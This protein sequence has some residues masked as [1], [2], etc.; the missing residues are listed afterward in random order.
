MF[1]FDTYRVHDEAHNVLYYNMGANSVQ[2]S[3][4]TYSSYPSKEGGKNKTVGQFEVIGKA[5]DTSLGGFSFDVKL[6]ELM[7]DRFNAI[8][9]K[10]GGA[11]QDLRTFVRPMTRLRNEAVKIKEVLSA[12]NEYPIKAEQLHANIDLVGKITRT[13]LE[14]ACKDLFARV[15]GPIQAALDM[16]NITIDQ[17]H[18]VELLGGGV[19]IPKVKKLLDDFFKPAKLDLGQHLNGDE[20]MALGASFRAAN[21]S[22]AFRVRKVGMTDVNY[23]GVSLKLETLPSKPGFFSSLFGSGKK[24]EE[25]EAWTKQASLY[26][27]MSPVPAKTKVVAFT[28]DKDILCRVEYDDDVPLPAGTHPLV[29]VYNITGITDFAQETEGKGLG[30]PKVHLSFSLDSNGMV[31]LNKAEATVDLPVEAELEPSPATNETSSNGSDAPKPEEPTD[32]AAENTEAP[33]TAPGQENAA[34]EGSPDNAETPVDSDADKKEK[35]PEKDKSSKSKSGKK[36][37]KSSAPKKEKETVLRRVLAIL[38]NHQLPSPT[39]WTAAEIAHAGSRLR[40]LDLEDSLRRAKEAA[41]NELEAYVYQVKNRLM[42]DEKELSKVSTEEQR[43]GVVDAA[44]EAAEWIDMEG[45]KGEVSQFKA[46]QASLKDLAEPIFRRYSELSARPT[47]VSKAREQLAGVKI[48]IEKWTDTMPHIT[49]EE[50]GKL[51]S[52]VDKVVAWLDD[53]ETAQKGKTK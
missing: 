1:N 47:A 27:R 43:Q 11:G 51:R 17:L 40:A 52:E 4:V 45:A 13:E 3:I 28:Y 29:A 25:E 35:T 34:G 37:R 19:R 15:T 16:A 31:F 8:W 41:L 7:A 36:D 39:R 5:W 22:T 50:K 2:V 26:P 44:N 30:K 32:P 14:E 33:E 12:N 10:K 18:A 38:E 24:V 21:L 9:A 46:K 49:D 20:A 48:M 42:D 23:F 6:A 53:K